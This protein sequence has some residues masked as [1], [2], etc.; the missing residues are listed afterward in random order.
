[1]V[2]GAAKCW[3]Y[4]GSG[5]LGNGGTS[6]S[7]TPVDV[8]G[9][10]SG[11][12]AISAG[13]YHSC[14]IVSGAAKCWGYG[15]SGQLGNGGTS[16]SSTPV[17]VTGLSSG[18]TAISAGYY[19]SCAIVSGAAKCWGYGVY[20]QLGNGS[21]IDSSTPV[22]V[23]GLSS[24]PPA[25]AAPAAPTPLSA[26]ISALRSKIPARKLKSFA[27]TAV[28]AG[29][30]KVEIALNYAN[31]GLLKRGKCLSVKNAKGRLV[32]TKA[33]KGKCRP[34]KWLA[35]KGTTSW[36]FKLTK[37]LKPGKYKLYVRAV[38]PSGET[39]TAFAA[40]KGNLRAF[41]VTR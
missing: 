18:V 19:H 11:V 15:T 5:R 3:G 28:G 20:G 7:S 25:P 38:G 1:M 39:Q 2:S 34:T 4:G 32:T 33:V 40:S 26:T 6:N 8:T 22:D 41:T 27:G 10:S 9:L 21:K 16:N 13:T 37:K 17:G 36:R 12:T 24:P 23:T 29:I 35:A 31:K 30:V 14:A